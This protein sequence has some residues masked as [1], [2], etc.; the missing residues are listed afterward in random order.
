MEMDELKL[1]WEALGVRVD[2]LEAEK[3][4]RRIRRNY[5]P[6]AIDLAF[7][8]PALLVTGSFCYD[9][10]AEPRFLIPGLV[11]H[12]ALI[13]A[14]GSGIRQLLA[15]KQLDLADSVLATQKALLALRAE[16]LRVNRTLLTFIPLLWPP[17]AICLA[18]GL[19]GVSLYS[20][21]SLT[22]LLANVVFGVAMVPV[23]LWF[24]RRFESKLLGGELTEAL[25]ALNSLRRFGEE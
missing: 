24:A 3:I 15:L 18:K 25:D 14:V 6:T 2:R 22:W 8:A 1:A 4:T 12:L 11:L 16:R 9:H 20:P 19:L 21:K 17:L 7:H 10:R 5:V 13:L 23:G